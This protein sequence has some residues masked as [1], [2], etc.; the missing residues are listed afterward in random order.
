MRALNVGSLWGAVWKGAAISRVGV[1]AGYTSSE[2]LEM[3]CKGACLAAG[4]PQS[5][6]YPLLSPHTLMKP[7]GDIP[8]MPQTVQAPPGCV[9]LANYLFS[10]WSFVNL[11]FSKH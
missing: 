10:G 4:V 11:V 6:P 5:S 7:K 3:S 2:K 9:F 1:R 8:F